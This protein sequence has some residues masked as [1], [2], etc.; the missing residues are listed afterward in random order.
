M[1]DDSFNMDLNI[2]KVSVFSKIKKLDKKY[3]KVGT[4]EI[5][6]RDPFIPPSIEKKLRESLPKMRAITANS[7]ALKNDIRI[8][9]IKQLL[10]KMVEEGELEVVSTSSRL[11]V[12]R[13]KNAQ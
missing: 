2:D 7:L 1:S 12:Y 13:G 8:G 3:G 9:T 6:K 5:K 4:I 10:N 11:R